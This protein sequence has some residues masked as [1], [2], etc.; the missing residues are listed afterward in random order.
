MGLID[1]FDVF[2]ERNIS[3]TCRR[4]LITHTK[5]HRESWAI[6][7]TGKYNIKTGLETKKVWEGGMHLFDSRGR[8]F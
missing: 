1:G 6:R 3:F 7:Y 4:E 2:K 8:L 5:F